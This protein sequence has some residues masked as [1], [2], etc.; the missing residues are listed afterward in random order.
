MEHVGNC[1]AS[2]W[3]VEPS[4]MIELRKY[5]RCVVCRDGD[6]RRVNIREIHSVVNV[7]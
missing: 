6:S 7:G 3:A 2:C 5:G 4:V 1:V